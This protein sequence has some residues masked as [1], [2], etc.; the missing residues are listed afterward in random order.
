MVRSGGPVGSA[1]CTEVDVDY[2][3]GEPANPPLT[4]SALV[5]F[6]FRLVGFFVGM[7]KLLCCVC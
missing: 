7:S 3:C 6:T 2:G 5:F 4:L 1:P